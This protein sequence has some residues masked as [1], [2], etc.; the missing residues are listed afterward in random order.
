MAENMHYTSTMEG[1]PLSLTGKHELD[2][3]SDSLSFVNRF[4]GSHSACLRELVATLK[5]HDNILH[6]I[7][8]TE[9]Y[10]QELKEFRQTHSFLTGE[11]SETKGQQYIT[12][13]LILGRADKMQFYMK[14]MLAELSGCKKTS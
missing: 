11:L 4:V 14:E 3:F 6:T 7:M 2:F 8:D 12:D 10:K 5:P 9:L 13:D 1:Y